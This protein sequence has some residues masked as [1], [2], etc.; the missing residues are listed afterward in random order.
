M[1]A[2]IH[3]RVLDFPLVHIFRFSSVGLQVFHAHRLHLILGNNWYKSHNIDLQYCM[4]SVSYSW[5]S[6]R[7]YCLLQNVWDHVNTFIQKSEDSLIPSSLWDFF[8]NY[9]FQ[10]KE[11]CTDMLHLTGCTKEAIWN[12]LQ[13]MNAW[14]LATVS[15][16]SVA[17]HFEFLCWIK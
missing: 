7:M 5:A 12:A 3:C 8:S 16:G 17:F 13:E 15:T 14:V 4:N 10:I 9:I 6:V 11:T 1:E 2:Y